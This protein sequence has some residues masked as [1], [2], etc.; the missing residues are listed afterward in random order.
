MSEAKY[1]EEYDAAK[2]KALKL[3]A[4]A[5]AAQREDYAKAL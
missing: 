3:A 1:W 4:K 5:E 2:A